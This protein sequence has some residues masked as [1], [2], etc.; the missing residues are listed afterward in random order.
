[1]RFSLEELEY[2]MTWA[3]VIRRNS[4]QGGYGQMTDPLPMLRGDLRR[5][6][7]DQRDCQQVEDRA[8]RLGIPPA[9]VKAVLDDL[10]FGEGREWEGPP[11][12]GDEPAG[13]WSYPEWQPDE[14]IGPGLGKAKSSGA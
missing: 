5:F 13:Q 14:E 12:P 6:E 9:H 2:C 8:L 4:L 10:F 7:H 11:W 3:R 1:M